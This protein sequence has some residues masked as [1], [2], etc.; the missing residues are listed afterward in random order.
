MKTFSPNWVSSKKP[1]KQRKF[2]FNAP[3]HLRGNFMNVH[4][5]KELRT[6]YGIRALRVR[7]G[8]K[9]R[10]MRGQFK[11]QE[12]K[13]EE[14]NMKHLKV[15]ISKI[16]HIK[17]DGSKAR[18]PIDPSN[19]LLVELNL[20]DK[21]RMPEKKTITEKVVKVKS[22]SKPVAPKVAKVKTESKDTVEKKPAKKVTK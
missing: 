21:K 13:I 3:L 17:R 10:I 7:T 19:L 9:V 15:Y 5:S 22:E 1:N 18:Y 4:L 12:G 8:D 11:R 16:E 2:R 14:V 20:D 6:K